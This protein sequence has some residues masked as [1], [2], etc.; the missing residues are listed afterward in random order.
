[1][2]N[3]LLSLAHVFEEEQLSFL[4]FLTNHIVILLYKKKKYLYSRRNMECLIYKRA[5]VFS[6]IVFFENERGSSVQLWGLGTFENLICGPIF[7][8]SV[9]Q[10]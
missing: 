5:E 4:C 7:C 2:Q 1:M 8:G 10:G 9:R 6:S 3:S